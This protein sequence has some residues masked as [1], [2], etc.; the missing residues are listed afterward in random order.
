MLL[1]L[2]NI[3]NYFRGREVEGPEWGLVLLLLYLT[4]I[5][6]GLTLL[7][8]RTIYTLK[9]SNQDLWSVR[10]FLLSMFG[11][12]VWNVGELIGKGL[13]YV[14]G[15]S[16]MIFVAD[17]NIPLAL[18]ALLSILSFSRY[19]QSILKT[20]KYRKREKLIAG[21]FLFATE[22]ASTL[23]FVIIT[24][25][26][27]ALGFL[28][29]SFRSETKDLTIFALGILLLGVIVSLVFVT[30]QL[31]RERQAISS[32]LNQTRLFFYIAYYI[33]I[34]FAITSMLLSLVIYNLF[35]ID[36]LIGQFVS[37]PVFGLSLVAGLI[38]YYGLFMPVWLQKKVGVLPSF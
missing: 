14:F 18:G 23:A 16:Y 10:Y 3:D 34:L 15:P 2:F 25:R 30:N 38:L 28:P 12:I 22:V 26:F 19:I 37:Y 20:K 35:T 21:R 36:P 5:T 13:S 27:L 1:M 29:S 17:E 31:Y 7:M 11:L 32:K 9:Q 24:L 6:G 4:I 33:T 8:G